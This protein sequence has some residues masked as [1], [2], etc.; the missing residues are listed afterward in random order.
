[1]DSS[2]TP[3]RPTDLDAA[4]GALQEQAEWIESV[5]GLIDARGVQPAGAILD[6]VVGRAQARGVGVSGRTA[7]RNTIPDAQVPPYPGDERVEGRINAYLRWNAMA[8]VVRA[9][10]HHDGIGGHLSTYASTQTLWEVGFEHFFHGRGDQDQRVVP[11]DQVFFQGHASPGIYA[12]AYLEG[13]LSEQELDLFRQEVSGPVRGL[14]SY[15]HPRAMGDF[16][17][18]PTVSLGIGP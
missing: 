14:P 15:P 18:F 6:E 1:M 9:N 10:K 17:E 12:R 2:S 5:D 11:G 4:A 13:R 3:V 8:M 7:Y 16:W